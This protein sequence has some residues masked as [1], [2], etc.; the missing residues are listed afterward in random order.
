[1]IDRYT[2]TAT[3]EKIKE[4]F[5][6]EV[7]SSYQPKFNAAPT[8]LL[9]VITSDAP[10]GMAIFYWGTSPE[11]SKNKTLS[12]KIINIRAETI[13]EKPALKRS[14]MRGRCIIPADG[15]YA[16]K[17]AGKKSLIPY[18]FVSIAQELFSFAGL[19]EEFED[20]DGNELHTFSIITVA[21]NQLVSPIH[22][23]MPVMLD[24]AGER[25]WLDKESSE[26]VLLNTLQAYP[27]GKMNLYSISPRIGDAKVDLPSLILP[28]PPADQYGN[29]TLFD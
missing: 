24:A 16:W 28:T 14:M 29:L 17:K 8:Q 6:I 23:R 19:W 1:M 10:Q 9:P 2:I 21:A 11:W 13:P 27:H 25:T 18:R 5:S 20:T 3:P 4:R 22:D 7:H 12:E 26:Q 15:F